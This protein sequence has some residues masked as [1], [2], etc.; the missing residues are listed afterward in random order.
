MKAAI[1]ILVMLVAGCARNDG[2]GSL[3]KGVGCI[4]NPDQFK[5][6]K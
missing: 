1:L 4:E 3:Y 5:R 2:M 6:C